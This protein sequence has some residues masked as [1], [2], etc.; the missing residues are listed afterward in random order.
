MEE[1][2]EHIR[3]SC[4]GRLAVLQAQYGEELP[5]EG[6]LAPGFTF[7]GRR[8]PFLNRQKGIYRAAIQRGPAALSIQTSANSPYGDEETDLGFFYDYRAG[9]V[10][11]ADNRALRQ[12]HALQVPLVYFVG[13]RPGLY[14][15][16]YP[17]YVMNDDPATRRVVIVPGAMTGPVDEPEAAPLM[18]TVERKYAVRETR[19]RLHQARFRGL[20]LPAYR[21]QCTICRLREVRLLD[22][23]HITGDALAEG[24]AQISNGLSFCTIHHRAF[25]Q[26]L[27]GIS[28]DYTVHVADRLL[29]DEDGPMLD[30]LKRFDRVMI[31]LPTREAWHPN[32][33]R[34][35]DRFARFQ[36]AA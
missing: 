5:F 2:D 29:D 22:A 13:T 20:V 36:Q 10:D 9:S 28:S 24:A 16:V 3:A 15:P 1:R 21:D 32:R 33:E 11:Q 17:S 23:A 30:V 7:A 12:A 25:D 26:D 8:V 19:V 35:A 14:R 4:F 34:L 18:D 6:A 31:Q 27:V